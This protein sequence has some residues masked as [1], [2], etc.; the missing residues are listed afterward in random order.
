MPNIHTF[1]KFRKV[2]RKSKENYKYFVV[3][4]MC[5]RIHENKRAEVENLTTRISVL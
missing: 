3:F 2:I 4:T 1:Q 5:L